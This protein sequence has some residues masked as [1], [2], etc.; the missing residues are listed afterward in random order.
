[1]SELG[2]L[3]CTRAFWNDHGARVAPLLAGAA[4]AF[5]GDVGAAA[6]D[7]IGI[8]YFSN[9]LWDVGLDEFA[10]AI[11][12]APNLRWLQTATAGTDFWL[13]RDVL[14]RGVTVT[15][16]SGAAAATIA[17]TTMMYV[18]AMSRGLPAWLGAQARQEWS[19]HGVEDL[20]GAVLGVVGYGPIGQAV[21]RL[22]AAFGMDVR[23]C[24]RS[25]QPADG[26]TTTRSVVELASDVDWLVLAAPLTPETRCLV[27]ADVL[28][29]MRPGARLVNVGRGALVDEE[30]LADALVAGRLAGAAL[31]VFDVEPLPRGHRLW[32]T[33]GVIITPHCSGSGQAATARG[34]DI[35]V[36][37]L[38]RAVAGEALRNVV[39]TGPS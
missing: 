14:A 33:P 10:A 36:D 20:D 13:F 16:A 24:R 26:W 12:A 18:L 15:T 29:A 8:A 37:N 7:A 4:P 31:D 34:V 21:A 1:M 38:R 5:P 6:L 28:A 19:P 27:S 3:L 22:A 39:D 11:E 23:V 32:T 9:D 17:H 2:R 35:F 25:P 30:A